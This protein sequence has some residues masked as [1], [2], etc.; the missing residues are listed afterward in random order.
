M[1]LWNVLNRAMT[2]WQMILRGLPGW[3]SQFTIS[4]PGL[5][6]A[7]F[8]L[9]FVAFL[10]V[11][12]VSIG[13]DV[14]GIAPVIAS[15]FALA[16]PALAMAIAF[17]GTRK[18]VRDGKP[19]Y[20][21][22]VPGIYLMAVF[23]LLE[24]TLSAIGGPLALLSWIALG[25]CLFKLARAAVDWP[26]VLSIGFAVLTLVLLAAMRSALYMVSNATL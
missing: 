21:L 6:T 20:D 19:V 9:A 1:R 4:L 3:R 17:Q 13:A 25:Y 22:L 11:V 10:A 14:P 15:M 18:A 8:V 23:I 26:L 12:L 24:G 7:L 2:G 5:A 16:L